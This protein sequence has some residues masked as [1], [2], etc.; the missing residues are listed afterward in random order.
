MRIGSYPFKQSEIDKKEAEG[1]AHLLFY[2]KLM[3]IAGLFCEITLQDQ[4]MV[5]SHIPCS[6]K[7]ARML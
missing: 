4:P 1:N 2:K 6:M 3:P 5:C 7:D